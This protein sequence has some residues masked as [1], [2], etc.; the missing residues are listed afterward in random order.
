M[1]TVCMEVGKLVDRSVLSDRVLLSGRQGIWL[2]R[3]RLG[4]EDIFFKEALLDE[5]FQIPSEGPTVDGLVPPTVVERAI[6][7]QPGQ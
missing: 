1:Y 3:N 4:S 5:F 2:L 7:L 6:L